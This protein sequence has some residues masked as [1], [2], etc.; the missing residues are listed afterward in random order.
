M[1]TLFCRDYSS[2]HRRIIDTIIIIRLQ[3]GNFT[4]SQKNQYRCA[5]VSARYVRQ[6]RPHIGIY[7]TR[8]QHAPIPVNIERDPLDFGTENYRVGK[9]VC[10]SGFLLEKNK[11]REANTHTLDQLRFSTLTIKPNDSELPVFGLTLV[12]PLAARGDFTAPAHTI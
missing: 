4:K 3:A 7:L 10:K 1:F 9:I 2:S 8:M 5:Q 6:S 12:F 11:R